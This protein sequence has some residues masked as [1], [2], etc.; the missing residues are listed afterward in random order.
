MLRCGVKNIM[1][2]FSKRKKLIIS[3]CSYTDNYARQE[4]I[5]GFPRWG[6]LLAEKLDMDLINLGRCGFGN[7]AIYT[8]LIEKMVVEKNVGFVVAMWSEF[9]RMSWYIDPESAL[10]TPNGPIPQE[11]LRIR[12]DNP[13]QCFLPER[14]VLDADWHDKFYKPP[15]ENP[16]KKFM[17]YELSKIVRAQELDS[18]RAGTVHSLGYMF[19]FQSICENMNIPYLQIQGCRAVP[20]TNIQNSKQLAKYIIESPYLNK[21]NGNFIGWPI[22]EFIG[23]YCFDS[24]LT[25]YKYRISEED[26]HPNAGGHKLISEILYNE[27]KKIY[28]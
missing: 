16:K 21:I 23:G 3:G 24:L 8:T 13:W 15:T 20:E 18:M 11:F 4:K 22:V 5:E 26:T 10:T 7:R 27:Y 9:Q 28:S 6:E 12:R 1:S 17:K 19:A 25:K 14:V 2:L